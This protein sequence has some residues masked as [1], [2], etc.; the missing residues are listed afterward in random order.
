MT[1]EVISQ[2]LDDLKEQNTKEHKRITDRLDKTNGDVQALKLWRATAEGFLKGIRS[3]GHVAKVL[4]GAA[5]AA[6][7]GVTWLVYHLIT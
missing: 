6:V 5:G 2:K 4:W 1:I 3:V 7:A